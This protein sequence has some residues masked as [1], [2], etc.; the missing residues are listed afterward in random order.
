MLFS[1]PRLDCLTRDMENMERE[2]DAVKRVLFI[3]S[4]N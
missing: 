3:K 1:L 4:L 2:R